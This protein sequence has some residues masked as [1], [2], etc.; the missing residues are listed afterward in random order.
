MADGRF[1][2]IGELSG[3]SAELE[4]AINAAIVAL[5][6]A[7]AASSDIVVTL[8]GGPSRWFYCITYRTA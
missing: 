6:P 7:P 1:V 5:N 8:A 4:T 2:K 3:S